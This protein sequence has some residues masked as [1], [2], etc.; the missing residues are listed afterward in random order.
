ML[1]VTFPVWVHV[2]FGDLC[3]STI[4]TRGPWV[5]KRLTDTESQECSIRNC[6]GQFCEIPWNQ[7]TDVH[8]GSTLI[9]LVITWRWRYIM[10][11]WRH[12]NHVNTITSLSAA[13][14]RAKNEVCFFSMKYRFSDI[15]LEKKTNFIYSAD[16]TFRI[17]GII[18]FIRAEPTCYRTNFP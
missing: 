11:R 5:L 14:Q 6:L 18:N 1:L 10:W 4:K 13:K 2:T 12:R 3:C 7:T 9:T 17:I 15:L 16:L 8:R